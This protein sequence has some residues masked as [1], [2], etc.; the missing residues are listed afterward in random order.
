MDGSFWEK[1]FVTEG[2]MNRAERVY[3]Y[4]KEFGSITPMEAFQ[5]L[6]YTRLACAINE[7]KRDGHKVRKQYETRKNRF[8]QPVTYARYFLG[9]E[10]EIQNQCFKHS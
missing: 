10:N 3:S 2:M 5:D 7:M 8:G 4:M 6:G 1:L 9:D